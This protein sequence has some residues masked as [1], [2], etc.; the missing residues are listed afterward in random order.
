MGISPQATVSSTAIIAEDVDIFPG[1]YIGDDVEIGCG[2]I[3]YP[4]VTILD[5]SKIGANVR[6]FP[7]VVLYEDTVVGDRSIIHGGAVIG[8]Y[9]FGYKSSPDG[10]ALSPQLGNVVIGADVEIGSNSTI[11]RG[12]FESTTIGEGTKL[13]DQVMIGHNCQIGRHNLLCSQVGVAG[14]CTTGDFVVMGG[15]VGLADH[16]NIGN[17]VFLHAKCGVMYDVPDGS[18]M[19][20]A[21]ALP[22]R[23][24]MQFIAIKQ[25]LPEMKKQ[26]RRLEKQLEKLGQS[27]QLKSNVSDAA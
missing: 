7:S 1:A 5:R 4:N 18:A 3:I 17:E 23:Q 20:G 15:Q 14:S 22:I 13:D 2:S 24:E 16:L 19:L 10:H 8:G 27:G 26:I 11:D 21:P 12:T 6:V 9:G 25:K